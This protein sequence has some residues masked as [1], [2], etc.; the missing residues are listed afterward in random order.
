MK[1]IQL[2]TVDNEARID[3]RLLSNKLKVKHK[4]TVELI[5]KYR[6]KF[7][8]FGIIPFETCK[9]DGAGRP[10]RFYLLNED[11]SYF[12][13]SLSK[14]TN[15]VVDLKADLVFAFS[16]ARKNAYKESI[17]EM[18]LLPK[19]MSWEKRFQPN[20]YRALARVTNTRYVGHS[21]GTPF[22]FAQITDRW[23]YGVIMPIDVLKE[24]KA[25]REDSQKLHQ[26]L[27]NGG[28][29]VLDRQ[30]NAVTMIANSSV[31]RADFN[32]RCMQVFGKKGQLALVYPNAS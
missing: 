23:V 14:N 16:N 28:I 12:L 27:T 8:R 21:N 20:F 17:F 4:N 10:E 19:P 32:A 5:N 1:E 26:W 24:M 25:R 13:L 30:I 15:D 29:E 2:V 9:Y 31:D 22:T 3:S 11:Q 7:E 18:F 6:S